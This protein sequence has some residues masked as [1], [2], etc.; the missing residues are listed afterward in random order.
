MGSTEGNGASI[1]TTLSEE[2]YSFECGQS[3]VGANTIFWDQKR[4]E[5][6]NTVKHGAALAVDLRPFEDPSATL[7][8]V[9]FRP[10][11]P[12]VNSPSLWCLFG[13][14]GTESTPL[15][16]CADLTHLGALSAL[17]LLRNWHPCPPSC[18][19]FLGVSLQFHWLRPVLGRIHRFLFVVEQVVSTNCI[20][21]MQFSTVVWYRLLCCQAT[22]RVISQQYPQR[23]LCNSFQLFACRLLQ[24][25]TGSHLTGLQDMMVLRNVT[26]VRSESTYLI[27]Y[28][29]FE[30][31][32]SLAN[33][34]STCSLNYGCT[35]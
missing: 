23:M 32:S 33:K 35:E 8:V 22:Q 30:R 12:R 29:L 10:D 16:A 34:K 28:L 5:L 6:T 9:C 15:V 21:R 19:R 26:P 1:I 13:E 24:P 27:M 25:L 11:V 4:W 2:G 7:R 31:V 18:V 3:A 20:V 14:P 17:Q